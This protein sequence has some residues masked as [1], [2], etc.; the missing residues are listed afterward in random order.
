MT[1]AFAGRANQIAG[2]QAALADH[3]VVT[4]GVVPVSQ[5]FSGDT[6][7]RPLDEIAAR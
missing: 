3:P 1:T 7:K 2:G 6:E 5:T 4:P